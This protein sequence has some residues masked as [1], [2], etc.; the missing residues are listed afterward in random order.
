[1]NQNFLLFL[2]FIVIAVFLFISDRQKW[3][4]LGKWN[5]IITISLGI[6]AV[7]NLTLSI[8]QANPNGNMLTIAN[9]TEIPNSISGYVK[10]NEKTVA[11]IYIVL[12]KETCGG[13][14]SI[15][16]T[17]SDDS[18]YFYFGN[19]EPGQYVQAV[20]WNNENL[21]TY[22][23][24]CSFITVKNGEMVHENLNILKTDLVILFPNK[25]V[26]TIDKDA[27]LS[28]QEYPSAS[29]YVAEIYTLIR[30]PLSKGV[31]YNP[32]IIYEKQT[33]FSTIMLARELDYASLAE[34]A[35]SKNADPNALYQLRV[36]AFNS[37]GIPFA[38]NESPEFYI[39]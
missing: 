9:S 35:E 25:Q 32:L 31:T 6:L 37:N 8:S 16:K 11:G 36:T 23:I 18:G 28:W 34:A 2:F 17:V 10:W 12:F 19:L 1:M 5:D 38:T 30:K 22:D 21:E 24:S 27:E 14:D 3:I 29:Y 7:I 4:N 15:A 26:T 39:K 13:G 20:N 33:A